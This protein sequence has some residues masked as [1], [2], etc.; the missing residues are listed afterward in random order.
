MVREAQ[1]RGT[2]RAQLH[3][4]RDQAGVV[5]FTD[6]GAARRGLEDALAQ[7]AVFKLG[8]GRLARG[9]LQRDHPLA[10]QLA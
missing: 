2:L 3:H 10:R 8:Q 5:E 7:A 6:L 1:Q 4:L 9:V